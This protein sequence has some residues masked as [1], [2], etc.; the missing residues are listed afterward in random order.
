MVKIDRRE[1]A[2][3]AIWW[4]PAEN[5][6]LSSSHPIFSNSFLFLLRFFDFNP[7]SFSGCCCFLRCFGSLIIFDDLNSRREI[8]I[9]IFNVIV[10]WLHCLD[11]WKEIRRFRMFELRLI[12]CSEANQFH[13]TKVLIHQNVGKI[14]ERKNN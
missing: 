4:T 9:L 7:I 3:K 14:W 13:R 1:I 8:K 6:W 12:V 2:T 11:W 5:L 10:V